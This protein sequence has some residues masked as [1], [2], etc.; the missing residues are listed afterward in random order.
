M[1]TLHETIN[2]NLKKELAISYGFRLRREENRWSYAGTRGIKEILFLEYAAQ[3][4]RLDKAAILD[5]VE[6]LQTFL[7]ENYPA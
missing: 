2:E 5:I 3:N 4:V 1:P 6:F 7:K